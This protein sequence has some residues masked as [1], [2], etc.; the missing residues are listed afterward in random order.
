MAT[1]KMT[2][3]PP[4]L[5]W[6]TNLTWFALTLS[7]RCASELGTD[8]SWSGRHSPCRRRNRPLAGHGIGAVFVDIGNT[9]NCHSHSTPPSDTEAEMLVPFVRSELHGLPNRMLDGVDFAVKSRAADSA[10]HIRKAIH[11]WVA[12]LLILEPKKRNLAKS[13][14]TPA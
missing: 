3:F 9:S 2:V 4:R 6:L 8:H 1:L 7:V 12:P 13:W 14:L 10:Y 11:S 5:G